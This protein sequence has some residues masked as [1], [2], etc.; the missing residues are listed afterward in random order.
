MLTYSRGLQT[1]YNLQ[2]TCVEIEQMSKHEELKLIEEYF[3]LEEMFDTRTIELFKART[4][5][6]GDI[7]IDVFTKYING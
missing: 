5:L 2:I 7:T 1:T 3:A 4:N 6:K